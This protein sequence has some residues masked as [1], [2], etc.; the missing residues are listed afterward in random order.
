[1]KR[2][3]PLFL[4]LLLL[5]GCGGAATDSNPPS[6]THATIPTGQ[7]NEGFELGNIMPPMSVTTSDG[8][9]AV[10][11]EVLQEKKLVVLNFWY[12]DCIWCQREFPALE[13]AYSKYQQDVEIFALN[14]LDEADVANR[15]W[16]SHDLTIPMGTCS[17]DMATI[18][19]VN[20]YPTSV[21]IDREGRIALI[22]GGALTDPNDFYRLFDRF[23][24]EDYT[25][26]GYESLQHLLGE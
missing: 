21:F 23:L 15:F 9:T 6:Q 14:P 1:M 8:E 11:G 19:G 17:R 4:S 20:G 13:L 2:I 18:F 16:D 25:S 24:A 26:Q 7:S 3:I 12:A 5:T 10:L 22:H